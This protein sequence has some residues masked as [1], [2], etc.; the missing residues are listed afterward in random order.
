MNSL[1]KLIHTG[2]WICTQCVHTICFGKALQDHVR[3]ATENC[4]QLCSRKA[5]QAG[6]EKSHIVK[7]RAELVCT[8]QQSKHTGGEE[9]D[10]VKKMCAVE[11]AHKWRKALSVHVTRAG[12]RNKLSQFAA[13]SI[14]CLFCEYEQTTQNQL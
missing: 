11:Y 8:V 14:N 1:D 6:G 7:K 2:A 10:I 12:K 3:A 9:Y 4:T 5:T 13:N